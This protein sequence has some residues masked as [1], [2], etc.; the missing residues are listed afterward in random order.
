MHAISHSLAH[1][2]PGA[3]RARTRWQPYSTSL[4]SQTPARTPSTNY[5]N[6]PASSVSSSPP[7]SSYIP[8]ICPNDRPKKSPCN[9][10]YAQSSLSAQLRDAQKTRYVSRLVDQTVKALCDIW[11]PDD[12][13]TVFR[14]TS[15][16]AFSGSTDP[17]I[18]Q[19]DVTIL[20][21]APVH[22]PTT[23]NHQ[24]PSPV[25][26]SSRP[27]PISPFTMT[28]T[29]TTLPSAVDG[30]SVEATRQSQL[31]PIKGFVHEV[32][33][34]S[35]T[36][37]GVLQTAL[38][39]LEAIRGKIPDLLHQEQS[40][41]KTSEYLASDEDILSSRITVLSEEEAKL[42]PPAINE[43]DDAINAIYTY[44]V[45]VSPTYLSDATLDTVRISSAEGLP[46]APSSEQMPSGVASFSSLA[47]SASSTVVEAASIPTKRATPPL[48]PLPYLP[49]PLL[50]PRRTFLACLI[51]ASKF[52]QDRSYSN[53]AWAKLAGLPAREI[54]RCERALG[55]LLQWRLWVGK[56]SSALA[57]SGSVKTVSRCRSE[58][59]LSF[60]AAADTLSAPSFAA[61]ATPS[62][63]N[64]RRTN[65]G[66]RRSAT[67]P[68]IGSS[69]STSKGNCSDSTQDGYMFSSSMVFAPTSVLSEEPG[70]FLVDP[71][72]QTAAGVGATIG[73]NVFLQANFASQASSVVPMLQDD[74]SPPVLTPALSYYADSPMS[75]ASSTSS[76]DGERTIQMA[77]F[78]DMPQ[79]YSQAASYVNSIASGNSYMVSSFA[80][81]KNAPQRY[82][83]AKS[84]GA[85]REFTYGRNAGVG[86]Q[87]LSIPEA[88]LNPAFA[89]MQ[90]GS[91]YATASSLRV[92]E[93][94]GLSYWDG[95]SQYSSST[96]SSPTTL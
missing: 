18:S 23:N 38:C 49:S 80:G 42:L 17:L 73:G 68:S 60:V 92:A 37:A 65:S 64:I 51:L 45:M 30:G 31:V 20:N 29:P 4:A 61:A 59:D 32:L 19:P 25:T 95:V 34:R 1:R 77:G 50:C 40:Q 62:A 13:P 84:L 78:V 52:M 75:C 86:C 96:F 15:N 33:R 47:T 55:E 56:G 90:K 9:P 21:N 70:T 83:A 72:A 91:V 35:R 94:V 71:P 48:P 7:S 76:D 81:V 43:I 87:L 26:P 46:T 8:N 16:T 12:I 11:H 69:S 67:E 85:N 3:S 74:M 44:P 93:D 24:L 54:G 10:I 66:L 57:S 39:Y 58:A 89:N 88:P 53:R 5:L 27:S 28:C 2:G 14:T 36:S 82:L 41:P 22:Y 6:T 79:Y 63:A